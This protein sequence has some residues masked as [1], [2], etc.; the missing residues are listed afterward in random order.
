MEIYVLMKRVPDTESQIRIAADQRSVDTSDLNFIINPY[1]EYAIEAALQ[2]KESAGGT[3]T[4]LTVGTE[5]SES[6]IRKG[7]AMGADKAVLLKVGEYL[8]DARQVAAVLAAYLKNAGAD[9][10]LGGKQGVDQDNAS[11]ALM[12]AEMLGLPSVSTICSIQ[13]ENGGFSVE[14][15][16]EGGRESYRLGTPCL[17]TA[18]KGLNEPRYASL[19]GIMMAKKKPLE[20]AETAPAEGAV[21]GVEGLEYPPARPEGRIVGEGADAVPELLRLLKD[22]AKVF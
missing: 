9:L 13:A 10:I 4:L 12:L 7:L 15:E 1:D 21:Y 16:V 8:F 5:G 2:L 11:T 17:L 19:K 22:E 18:D 20:V 3:V 14:R 6:T